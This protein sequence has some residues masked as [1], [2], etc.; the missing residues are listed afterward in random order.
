MLSHRAVKSVF[1]LFDPSNRGRV[2]KFLKSRSRKFLQ[3]LPCLKEKDLSS[4]K[5]EQ[6]ISND[7][8]GSLDLKPFLDYIEIPN[9]VKPKTLWM[10]VAKLEDNLQQPHEATKKLQSGELPQLSFLWEW[11]NLKF[12]LSKNEGPMAKEM[13]SSMERR[14]SLFFWKWHIVGS[15]LFGSKK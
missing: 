9:V 12:H 8:A 14:K 7:K 10:D 11:E 5:V 13:M 4:N 15:N 3:L 6:Y 1:G 2:R